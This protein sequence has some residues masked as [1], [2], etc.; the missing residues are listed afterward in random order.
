MEVEGVKATCLFCSSRDDV[1]KVKMELTL[2]ERETD[3]K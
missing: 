2:S 3:G 1:N